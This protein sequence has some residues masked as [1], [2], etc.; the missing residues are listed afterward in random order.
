MFFLCEFDACRSTH[1]AY[2][3]HTVQP[4]AVFTL[5]SPLH[6]SSLLPIQRITSRGADVL[7]SIWCY[8]QMVRFILA[9]YLYI[10]VL[11]CISYCQRNALIRHIRQCNHKLPA[12]NGIHTVE[13]T[14]KPL[15][16]CHFVTYYL[17]I[18]NAMPYH[19][20]R[21]KSITAPK[22]NE[23]IQQFKGHKNSILKMLYFAVPKIVVS[24]LRFNPSCDV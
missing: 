20:I 21:R 15:L 22:N 16:V 1:A 23:R 11:D 6:S 17:Y 9:K 3:F 13:I 10:A 19:L 4:P 5:E 24:E 14:Q 8:T 2:Y 7:Y 18:R 12:L